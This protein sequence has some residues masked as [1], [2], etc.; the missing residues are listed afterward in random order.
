MI[1]DDAKN[2]AAR[3][4]GMPFDGKTVAEY[5]GNHGAFI[6][7]L[8]DIL[9]SVLQDTRRLTTNGVDGQALE[10]L[11]KIRWMVQADDDYDADEIVRDIDAVLE[12]A[13]PATLEG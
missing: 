3:F 6:S 1:M 9:I 11:R 4:D 13:L 7:A 8:A 12:N 2:D 10:L 5:F